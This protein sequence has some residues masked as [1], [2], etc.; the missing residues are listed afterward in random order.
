MLKSVGAKG[1]FF[2]TSVIRAS[3]QIVQVDSTGCFIVILGLGRRG[4]S[5]G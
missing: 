1:E 3:T 5:S 2:G 4:P